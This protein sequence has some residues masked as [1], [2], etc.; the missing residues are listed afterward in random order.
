LSANPENPAAARL[1]R[2]DFLCFAIAAAGL[3]AWLFAT[4]PP[5]LESANQITNT[6][7]LLAILALYLVF[8]FR[9]GFAKPDEP[10]AFA[11]FWAGGGV[12]IAIA[13]FFPP[14]GPLKTAVLFVGLG[15]FLR[16]AGGVLLDPAG[17]RLLNSLFFAFTLFGA[18]LVSLPFLD[19][20]LR[21]FAGQWSARIFEWLHQ[22]AELVVVVQEGVPMLLL[23]INDRP[24]HVA[25]ECN[26]F[27]LL[28][29]SL[30][31]TVAFVF[32]RKVSWLDAILLLIAAVFLALVG[33]LVRIFIIILLA[34]L[35]GDHYMLMHE[36]VGTITFYG[37]L[38]IQWWLVVGFGRSPGPR[39]ES[40]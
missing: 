12:L 10:A 6:A 30:L 7:I 8:D 16:A 26:G 9:P 11:R 38:A 40:D 36:I 20:P 32:Y 15:F 27:G 1:R 23:V 35:V 3:G 5:P 14:V 4:L 24:F 19:V 28:G 39:L 13:S 31:L 22:Q 29:T 17:R 21:I 37:F 33:N 25:A 34:P 18:L 2:P